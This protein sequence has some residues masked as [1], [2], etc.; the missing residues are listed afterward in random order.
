MPFPT[1]TPTIPALVRSCAA[2]YGDKTFLVAD[3]QVLTYVDLDLRS[4]RLAMALLAEGVGKGDHVGILMPNS[5]EWAI[6]WFATTRIG[7]VAVP[8]NT[9]YKASELAWTARHA[10]LKAILARSAFR[11][12]DFVERLEEA[13]PGLAEQRDP[14]RIVL[15]K[16]PYL[17][18]IAVWGACD[19]A[20]AT[21]L[22]D[23]DSP[24]GIDSDFLVDIESCVTPADDAMIIYTSGSTGD[25]KAPVHT[26]GT[27][28]RHTYNLTFDYGVTADTV[29]FTAMPFFWVGGLIT[30]VHA[31]IHHGATLVTQPAFDAAEALEL[32]ERHRATIALGWPQQG[33]TL[34]EHPDFA[35]RDLSSVKRT[36][37]P[38]MVPPDRRPQGPNALGMT[39]LCGNHIGVDPYPPQPPDRAE[40]GGISI[41]GLSHLLV[42][43]DTGTPVPVGTDGEIWVRG[44]SLMQRLYK[45]EREDV[46]TPDGYYRTGDCGVSY[47][48]GWIKFTGRLGDLIK[49]GGG[50]NVTPSEVELALADC[51]GVLEAYV[52]GAED[53]S[54][55]TVVAAAVVPRGDS[56]LDVEELRAQVRSRLSAYKV[57]KFVWITQKDALPFTAT[58]KVK[59]SDLAK[60]LSNLMTKR[61]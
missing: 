27:L 4:S 26:H 57:P 11:N 44:Y 41:D 10:D 51:D 32:I 36:S 38:A 30:G 12:H 48:D 33:K 14:G 22:G 39:E 46:F 18:T 3:G 25:P 7:A 52:V 6:A 54:N 58:G 49:T 47:D 19:R 29:M 59:K 17:R 21:V 55:G 50:T 37:M 2:R 56:E 15:R 13:L 42:D 8:L 60:Q 40:T 23:E 61:T 9:F 5:V 20:W 45:R 16:T 28:V 35:R 34:S 24:P 1:I 53:A 31:V 43:P